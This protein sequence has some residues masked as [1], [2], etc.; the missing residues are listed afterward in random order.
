MDLSKILKNSSILKNI[1]VFENPK[2][3]HKSYSLIIPDSKTCFIID[4]IKEDQKNY[5]KFLENNLIKDHFYISLNSHNTIFDSPVNINNLYYDEFGKIGICYFPLKNVYREN[6]IG[7]KRFLSFTDC[8]AESDKNPVLFVGDL[9]NFYNL[10]N[11]KKE[12]SKKALDGYLSNFEI[13]K[14][15]SD[16]TAVL[17]KN[18]NEEDKLFLE[19]MSKIFSD[20]L[21]INAKLKEEEYFMGSFYENKVINPIFYFDKCKKL[22]LEGKIVKDRKMLNILLEIMKEFNNN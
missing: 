19:I 6:G 9:F 16:Q 8:S 12:K 1:C 17:T 20:N 18:S 11:C 2:K 14:G 21:L 22:L 15:F 5:D 13:L 10:L 3:F 4:P 7:Q